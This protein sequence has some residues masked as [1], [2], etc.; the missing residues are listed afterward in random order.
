VEEDYVGSGFCWICDQT[1]VCQQ[2]LI[3]TS[4]VWGE[5]ADTG[6]LGLGGCAPQRATEVEPQVRRSGSKPPPISCCISSK[7]LYFLGGIVEIQHLDV[8]FTVTARA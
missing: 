6:E 8:M 5:I 2:A 4:E 1:N 3:Q 7:L